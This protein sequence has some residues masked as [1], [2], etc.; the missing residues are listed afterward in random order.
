MKSTSTEN[1]KSIYFGEA[2][3]KALESRVSER[4]GQNRSAVINM[5]ADRYNEIIRRSMPNLTVDEWFLLFDA[6]NGSITWDRADALPGQFIGVADA[7]EMDGL[8][9]KREVDGRA[10]VEKLKTMSF[11]QTVA[12]I[13]ACE[14]FWAF[15][16]RAWD[17]KEEALQELGI[18]PRPK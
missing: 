11:C 2:L 1:K 7:I 5:I 9:K 3:N 14:R 15:G 18:R 16:S 4:I 10:L 12:W 13:D 8:D 6:T 17:S